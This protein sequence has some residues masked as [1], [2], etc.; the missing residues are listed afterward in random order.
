MRD[1]P[2]GPKKE[3]DPHRVGFIGVAR[4]RKLLASRPCIPMCVS[5][6]CWRQQRVCE[7]ELDRVEKEVE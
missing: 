3:R 6:V 2:Q 7:R 1:E 5:M 4:D